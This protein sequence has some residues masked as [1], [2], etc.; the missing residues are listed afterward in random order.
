MDWSQVRSRWVKVGSHAQVNR[1]VLSAKLTSVCRTEASCCH[2]GSVSE[3]RRQTPA[4][5][6]SGLAA[7]PTHDRMVVV[8]CHWSLRLSPIF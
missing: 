6:S 5:F 4:K 8:A 1:F 3:Q 7:A 2:Q